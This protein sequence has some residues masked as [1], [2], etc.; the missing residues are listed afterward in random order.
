MFYT[1]EDGDTLLKIADKF[2]GDSIGWQRIYAANPDVIILLP[3]TQLFI[4]KD[5]KV[6]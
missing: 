5:A 3:G 6:D 2:Y 1:V 4:P